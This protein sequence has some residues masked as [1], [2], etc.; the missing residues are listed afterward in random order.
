MKAVAGTGKKRLMAPT[1]LYDA[2]VREARAA[3]IG[4]G[5]W[6]TRYSERLWFVVEFLPSPLAL[7]P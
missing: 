6:K 3:T 2:F 5:L 4:V 1:R 7:K